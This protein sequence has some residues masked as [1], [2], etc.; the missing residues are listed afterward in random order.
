MKLL[1]AAALLVYASAHGAVTYPPPRNAIDSDEKPWVDGLK[2]G[3]VP[4]EPWCPFPSAAAAAADPG[5]NL[6]GVNGQACFW[7][8]YTTPRPLYSHDLEIV[9]K[10]LFFRVFRKQSNGCAIG[11]DECDGNTRGPIPQFK[12]PATAG[13]GKCVPQVNATDSGTTKKINKLPVC[14]APR[15]AT[16]CDPKQ[17]TVNTGAA[18]G[19]DTDW[20]YYTPCEWKKNDF[21]NFLHPLSV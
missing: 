1:I 9:S 13:E 5:R 3:K 8:R 4:F 11:C 12:C 17:R 2:P 7:F 14:A 10:M 18:C 21:T 15:E 16:I 19:S 6:T 20:Y